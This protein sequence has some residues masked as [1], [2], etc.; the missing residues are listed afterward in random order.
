MSLN[1]VIV[2]G[3]RPQFIKCAALKHGIEAFKSDTRIPIKTHFVNTGQHYDVEMAKSIIDE[4]GVVFDF[5]IVHEVKRTLQILGNSIVKLDEYL[6]GLNTFPDY[7]IVMGDS[8]PALVGALVAT[9]REISIAHFEAGTALDNVQTPEVRNGKVIAQLTQL[10]FCSSDITKQRLE[11][12]KVQ[13]EIYVIGDMNREF[14]IRLAETLPSEFRDYS[15][16]SYILFTMHHQENLADRSVLDA[17]L[18]VFSSIDRKIVFVAHPRTRGLMK[19]WGLLNSLPSNIDILEPLNYTEMLTAIKNSAYVFT[20]SGGLQRE[21]Y[22]LK[23][24]C[25]ARQDVDFW[26]D[27]TTAGIH[28]RIQA[29]ARAIWSAINWAE[30]VYNQDFSYIESLPMNAVPNAINLLVNHKAGKI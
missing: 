20:D 1:L 21:S 10:H 9:K 14:T 30:E 27:F 2:A 18:N 6:N 23:K 15:P 22:Y 29:N 19:Q 5:T 11:A 3:V 28:K 13:G 17:T 16:N 24:R 7:M 12:S 26:P 8:N 25:I 4:L